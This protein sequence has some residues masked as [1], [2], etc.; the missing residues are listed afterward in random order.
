MTGLCLEEGSRGRYCRGRE[1]P[2][3]ASQGSDELRLQGDGDHER[4]DEPVPALLARHDFILDVLFEDLGAPCGDGQLAN[5][6]AQLYD[7]PMA[8]IKRRAHC[9]CG[10]P[11]RVPYIKLSKGMSTPA[12]PRSAC[13]AFQRANLK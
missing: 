6:E 10:K 5:L 1:G 9:S 12:W 11:F 8:C 13:W 2:P 4:I 7:R 3:P